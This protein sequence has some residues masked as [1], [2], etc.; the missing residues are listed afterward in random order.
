MKIVFKCLEEN[1]LFYCCWVNRFD[2]THEDENWLFTYNGENDVYDCSII[3][4]IVLGFVSSNYKEY[5]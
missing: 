2:I 1:H 5:A 3:K 4:R